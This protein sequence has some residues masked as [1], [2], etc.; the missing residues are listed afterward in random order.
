M[1]YHPTTL[2]V[3]KNML[4]LRI[5]NK[6]TTFSEEKKVLGNILLM[7]NTAVKVT[8]ETEGQELTKDTFM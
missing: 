1:K 2:N 5:P 3:S 7:I 8:E 4:T 6:L